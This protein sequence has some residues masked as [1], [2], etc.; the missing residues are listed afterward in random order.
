MRLGNIVVNAGCSLSMVVAAATPA[1]AQTLFQSLFGLGNSQQR[2][3]DV[4]RPQPRPYQSAHRFLP[5]RGHRS[6]AP[7]ASVSEP[8]DEEIGPPDSGGPYRTMCVRTCDGYY[9]PIRHD[10]QQRNFAPD[11]KSCR[12]ACGGEAKLFYFPENGGSVDT[13]LDLAGHKYGEL[14]HAFAYRKKLLQGCTCKAAP[15]SAGETARHQGYA[16]AEAAQ[17]AAEVSKA[18]AI[19]ERKTTRP[20]EGSAEPAPEVAAN[21]VPSAASIA[22]ESET[23]E[24]VRPEPVTRRRALRYRANANNSDDYRTAAPSSWSKPSRLKV[25]W[26]PG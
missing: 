5:H 1:P 6:Q 14:P 19:E 23:F 25:Y 3:L 8:L 15:W 20:D 2:S 24:P 22:P 16:F 18:A 7:V 10:A 11:V 9:F 17:K 4:M 26:R 12:A 13:M 21:T